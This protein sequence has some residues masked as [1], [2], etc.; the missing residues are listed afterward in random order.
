MRLQ[1]SDRLD[2]ISDPSNQEKSSSDN[3]TTENNPLG[4][5]KYQCSINK[6]NYLTFLIKFQ[7]ANTRK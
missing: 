1:Q 2:F 3:E 4:F 6:Q 7:M 5:Q